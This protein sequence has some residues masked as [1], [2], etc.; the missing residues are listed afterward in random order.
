MFKSVLVIRQSLINIYN[1][2]HLIINVFPAAKKYLNIID[3]FEVCQLNNYHK[4]QIGI[5]I[6]QT[7]IFVTSGRLGFSLPLTFLPAT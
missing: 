1:S 2:L 6:L 5:V 7:H 3:P 4:N